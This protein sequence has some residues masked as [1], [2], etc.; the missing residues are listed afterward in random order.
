MTAC[1]NRENENVTARGEVIGYRYGWDEFCRKKGVEY[2]YR[3]SD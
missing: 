3:L 1:F 2:I